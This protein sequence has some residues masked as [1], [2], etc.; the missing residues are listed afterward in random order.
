MEERNTTNPSLQG[1]GCVIVIKGATKQ[2]THYKDIPNHIALNALDQHKL[3]LYCIRHSSYNTVRSSS[4]FALQ[5][6]IHG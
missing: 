1:S 3:A 6:F 2:A 5:A 4:G